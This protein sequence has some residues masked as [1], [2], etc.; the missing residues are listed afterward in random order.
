MLLPYV[1]CCDAST[2]TELENHQTANLNMKYSEE[3]NKRQGPDHRQTFAANRQR[4]QARAMPP[5]VNCFI[6]RPKPLKN[7][8][9]PY[10]VRF[11]VLNH[12]HNNTY[13]FILTKKKKK[14]KRKLIAD[15]PH[16]YHPA[17][18]HKGSSHLSP[19]HALEIIFIFCDA[20]SA[21]LQLVNQWLKLL[22]HVPTLSV[23]KGRTQILLW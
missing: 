20:S 9:P 22:T 1:W 14:K 10:K 18:G 15:G 21:L 11:R 6:T 19:V 16:H 2:F 12:R 4:S 17:C 3:H 8:P 23:T 5:D 7:L 13:I